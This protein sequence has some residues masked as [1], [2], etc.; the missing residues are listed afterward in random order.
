MIAEGLGLSRRRT[1]D[2]LLATKIALLKSYAKSK[3]ILAWGALA[4][5]DKFKLNF[6]ELHRYIIAHRQD[7]L[8]ALEAARGHAKTAVGCMLVPLFQALE[9]P[10]TFQHYLQVQATEDKTLAVN[11]SIKL[12]L[13]QNELLRAAYGN[14]ISPDRWTNGQF[15]TKNG[16]CFTA[17]GAGQSIRGI[18]YR[19]KRPD[20][21]MCDDL[22]DE[23][24]VHHPESTLKKNA[25]FW[26]T[27]F[28]ARAKGRKSCIRITGTPVNNEDLLQQLKSRT[29]DGWTHGTFPA[30][31]DIENGPVLWP[32]LNTL[33]QLQRDA[34]NMPPTIFARELLCERR[35]DASSIIKSEWLTSWEYDPSTIHF[36]MKLQFQAGVL[37]ID[38]SI[39]KG[40]DSDYSGYAF[41]LKALRQGDALPIYFIESLA[42]ERL[43]FQERVDKAREYTLNRPRECPATVVNV[44]AISGFA[45]FGERV[46]ASVA[47]PC[48]LI[49]KVADKVTTLEKRSHIFQNK[50]IFLNRNI[51]SDLKRMLIHQLTTTAPKHDDIRDAVLLTLEDESSSWGSWV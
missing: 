20:F 43:T 27:L 50:R 47:V 10:L 17:V 5:P 42:N 48:K 3:N 40:K 8:M 39:G 13:E 7:D 23:T 9:E 28:P 41:V 37:G 36:D 38:P 11:S 2:L 25:W 46:A 51:D 22:Y 21:V 12:E 49:T 33:E 45:D 31:K 29:K 16:V 19:N 15:V 14:Q 35:D 24:D 4:M 6:C 30:T 1:E 44:E 32:E 34:A 26:S 18:N